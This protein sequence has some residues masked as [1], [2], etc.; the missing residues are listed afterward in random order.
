MTLALAVLVLVIACVNLIGVQLARIAARGQERAVRLALGASRLRLVRE[1]L[2]ESLLVSLA[3]G[4]LGLLLADC[5]HPAAG[6]A[7]DVGRLPGGL[8]R[9]PGQ[10][11]RPRAARVRPALVLAIALVLGTV[12]AWLGS[13]ADIARS[14]R[15]GGRGTTGRAHAR[16]R[17]AVV[18]IELVLAVVL[19]AAGGLFVRGL[20]QLAHGDAGWSLDGVLFAR[21]DLPRVGYQS[22]ERRQA[23]HRR[24]AE[25]VGALA[26]V[27]SSTLS[28]DMPVSPFGDGEFI[29]EGRPAPPP[30]R[31]SRTYRNSVSAEF[32]ET[33]DIELREGRGF[34]P[35]DGA[36]PTCTA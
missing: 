33:L 8:R 2:A 10:P 27:G 18:V 7:D 35:A 6:A 13:P 17:A 12:P 19:L 24:L 34:S 36:S 4:A 3:G 31:A 1:A 16:L 14:L 21:I 9:G 28:T 29:I 20:H 15:Q 22:P 26:G 23:F 25:R 32:F 5:V 11:V 30:G